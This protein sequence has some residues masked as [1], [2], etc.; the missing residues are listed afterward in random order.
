MNVR[1]QLRILATAAAIGV[2]IIGSPAGLALAAPNTTPQGQCESRGGIWDAKR[3]GCATKQ[4][5]HQNG[6][7]NHNDT[8]TVPGTG[9]GHIRL[10]TTYKC[11]G[12]TGQW[13][14]VASIQASGTEPPA[15]ADV[16]VLSR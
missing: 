10:R 1:T 5:T 6:L 15:P 11:N 9:P 14:Q 2:A 16:P 12:F 3:Q 8:V 13:E 4:C 7:Y